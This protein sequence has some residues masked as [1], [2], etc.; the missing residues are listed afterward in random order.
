V[1]AGHV[2]GSGGH[3]EAGMDASDMPGVSAFSPSIISCFITAFGGFGVIFHEIPATRQVW[4][5]APLAMVGAFFVA[6]LLLWALRK[7]FHNTQSSSESRLSNIIGLVGQVITP[8]P[9]NGV[10]E[11]AYVE[12]G[13]RYS[14]PA[15]EEKGSPIPSGQP[16]KITRV[17]GSQFF[18]IAV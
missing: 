18:V 13:A 1:D 5:S 3:A 17:D 7:L 12:K 15:R 2:D 11:I 6:S 10:G 14:A 4:A 16:V 9:A 8:I